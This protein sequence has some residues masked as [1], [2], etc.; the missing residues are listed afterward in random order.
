M[1]K[2]RR[3]IISV[4]LLVCVAIAVTLFVISRKNSTANATQSIKSAEVYLDTIS[5]DINGSGNLEAAVTASI[6]I[7]IGLT[8]DEIYVESGDTVSKGQKL[9]K[10]KKSSIVSALVD[11]E[12]SLESVEEKIDDDDLTDLELEEL[13]AEKADL[14]AAE[15]QLK[16]LKKNPVITASC[17]GIINEILISKGNEITKTSST[18]S[19]TS[20]GN[21]STGMQASYQSLDAF[22]E[23]TATKMSLIITPETGMIRNMSTVGTGEENATEEKKSDSEEVTTQTKFT[24]EDSTTAQTDS[25]EMENTSTESLREEST[26]STTQEIKNN[27][28]Q[29]TTESQSANSANQTDI[30][31]T[32]S[33]EQSN[34]NTSNQ[35][36]S[37]QMPANNNS[38]KTTDPSTNVT[39]GNTSISSTAN[40]EQTS[41]L[42][43]AYNT[44][45]FTIYSLDTVNV[46]I[47]VDELDILSVEEGQ[48]ATITLD[49]VSGETFEGVIKKVAT[50]SSSTSGNA[51]YTVDIEL[52]MTSKM[53][54]GMTASAVIH[55]NQAN[56][57][58]VIP[59]IALQQER[60]TTFVYTSQE[61]D[62]SLSG[63]VEV[64]TGLSDGS[65]VQII[66]GLE[67]GD[68]VYYTRNT[69]SDSDFSKNEKGMS[70]GNMIPSE[71]KQFNGDRQYNGGQ[72]PS[73]RNGQP[74]Q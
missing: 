4:T 2:K 47:S 58:P 70:I 41:N 74:P 21:G 27:T 50:V 33:K 39:A 19:T 67:E 5:E 34:N 62:G 53:R 28:S 37:G 3:I 36:K 69:N 68:T 73:E 6:S 7:P 20:T 24:E 51:K 29:S 13:N 10:I 46:S 56:N 11:I 38:G 42:Y 61:K 57:V 45:A 43:D 60:D 25:T 12:N 64:E 65:K 26:Q 72:R 66:S 22:Q 35:E 23:I 1:K 55:V 9:A 52:P 30:N 18:S 15:K 49:A 32:Q 48:S 40:T 16:I 17:D 59:M 44:E 63:K 14:E 54:L 71:G 8:V 31:S